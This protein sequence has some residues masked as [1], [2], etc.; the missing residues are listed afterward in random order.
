MDVV[1]HR[2]MA[3]RTSLL[4]VLIGFI[5]GL[6]GDVAAWGCYGHAAQSSRHPQ[7]FGKGSVEGIIGPEAANNSKEGGA[8]APT[9]FLGLPGSSGMALVIVALLPLG[10]EPGLG[11][12]SE[13]P[14]ILWM[15]VWA[16]A[17]S[18]IIAAFLINFGPA[19]PH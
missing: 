13:H 15:M 4:G 9:L 5:P 11:L 6:G 17:L 7:A 14:E 16:L 12:P 18:N 1:R 3:L 10:I 2:W 19:R 8:L